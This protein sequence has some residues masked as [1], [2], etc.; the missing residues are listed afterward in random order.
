MSERRGSQ[1]GLDCVIVHTALRAGRRRRPPGT[2]AVGFETLTV[3]IEVGARRARILV[4]CRFL[5]GSK[6]R[7][8]AFGAP[9]FKNDHCD[10]AH[11]L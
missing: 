2:R 9:L 11:Q 3:A 8:P 1:K 4:S 5:L 10:G 6:S 7:S